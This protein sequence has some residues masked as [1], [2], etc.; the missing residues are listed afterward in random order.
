[1]LEFSSCPAPVYLGKPRAWCHPAQVDGNIDAVLS[2]RV[3]LFA[4]PSAAVMLR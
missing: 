4:L 1:M 2:V 3:V